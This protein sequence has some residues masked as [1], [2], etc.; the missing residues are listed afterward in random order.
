MTFILQ[1][2]QSPFKHHCYEEFPWLAEIKDNEVF[3]GL[4]LYSLA[5]YF[6]F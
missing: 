4:G 1:T 6:V 2:Q 5:E 3:S